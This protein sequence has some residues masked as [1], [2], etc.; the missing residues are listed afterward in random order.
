MLCLQVEKEKLPQDDGAAALT[1]YSLAS[2][3]ALLTSLR[4]LL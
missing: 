4:Y 3:L 1:A 2:L